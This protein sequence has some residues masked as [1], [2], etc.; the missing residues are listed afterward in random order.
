[1]IEYARSLVTAQRPI[2]YYSVFIS[3]TSADQACAERLHADLQNKG[4]RCWFAPYDLPI[5]APIVGGIDAAI[6]L[7]DKL[8]IILSEAA[9]KSGWVEYE[10][11][12]ALTREN[13]ERRRMLFRSGS[14]IR[15]CTW[16]AP[17]P[18]NSAPATLVT[19]EP[20]K[21]TTVIKPHSRDCCVTL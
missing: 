4:V 13:T 6:R 17:G 1:M 5:G 3:Y 11:T 20:G 7:Y 8:L 14:M 10:V 12:L 18:R 9:V 16:R 19:S 15:C 2:D 21:T